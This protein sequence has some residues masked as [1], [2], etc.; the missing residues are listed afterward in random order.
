MSNDN[1]SKG[2]FS[3]ATAVLALFLTMVFCIQMSGLYSGRPLTMG[4]VTN[5][6]GS[7]D[8]GVR[9]NRL[10]NGVLPD[11]Q[12]SIYRWFNASAFLAPPAFSFGNDSRTEPQLRAPALSISIACS[13]K[14]SAWTK[15]ESWSCARRLIT[16]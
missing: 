5:Q 8:G 6:T 16:L 11:S 10:S 7:L 12:R 3:S 13:A 1:T 9:P 14:N 2:T 4:D 15:R